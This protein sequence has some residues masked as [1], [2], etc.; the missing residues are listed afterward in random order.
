MMSQARID[1]VNW[2]YSEY[3]E[4]DVQTS[5]L[6]PNSPREVRHHEVSGERV[7]FVEQRYTRRRA[8]PLSEP[9]SA[10]KPKAKLIH[11]VRRAEC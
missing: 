1:I 11:T 7:H 6:V 2:Q 4:M 5:S 10:H 9:I 8:A 3:A